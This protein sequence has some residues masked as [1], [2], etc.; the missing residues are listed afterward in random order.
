LL[1]EDSFSFEALLFNANDIWLHFVLSFPLSPE[2]LFLT[3][4]ISC[5]LF[6]IADLQK[7]CGFTDVFGANQ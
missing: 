3:D 7:N 6:F 1:I 5:F 2:S 4:L